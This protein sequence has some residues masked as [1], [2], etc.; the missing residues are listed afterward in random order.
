MIQEAHCI[1]TVDPA[2]LKRN[3][4]LDSLH[5]IILF[6]HTTKGST[7]LRLACLPTHRKREKERERERE[8]GREKPY[9]YPCCTYM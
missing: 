6:L 7:L 4:T 3:S 8:R 5:P 2:M 1:L 9:P